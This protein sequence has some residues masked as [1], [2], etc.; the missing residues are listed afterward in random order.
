MARWDRSSRARYRAPHTV[1]FSDL[2]NTCTEI[3]CIVPLPSTGYD[4]YRTTPG[5]RKVDL[6][7][8]PGF[9]RNEL[10]ARRWEEFPFPRIDELM[11]VVHLRLEDPLGPDS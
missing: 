3:L 1:T 7:A 9:V 8:D 4:G 6:H 5:D 11:F 10:L 2:E